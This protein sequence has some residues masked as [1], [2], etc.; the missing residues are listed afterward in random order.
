MFVFLLKQRIEIN[1]PGLSP[2][3]C[4]PIHHMDR[5]F[6]C[7]P[8]FWGTSSSWYWP[9]RNSLTQTDS[10]FKRDSTYDLNKITIVCNIALPFPCFNKSLISKLLGFPVPGLNYPWTPLSLVPGSLVRLIPGVRHAKKSNSLSMTD[11]RG[12]S[13]L[14][15]LI[16]PV[17]G[18]KAVEVISAKEPELVICLSSHWN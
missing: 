12:A 16:R 1:Q 8:F 5:V 7:E 15:K 14:D 10:R 3:E 13:V 6:G 17:S 11:D 2:N 9:L 4:C 18:R